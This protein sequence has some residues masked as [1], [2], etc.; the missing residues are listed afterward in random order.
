MNEI[1]CIQKRNMDKINIVLCDDHPTVRQGL[2]Y[3]MNAQDDLQV[4]GETDSGEGAIKL[5][6][7][8]AP[9]VVL[10][11]LQL[12]GLDGASA[13][14]EVKRISPRTQVVVLTSYGNN[15]D[16]FPALR[17]GATAYLLKDASMDEIADA[18]RR[19]ARGEV[20]FD[21]RIAHRILQQQDPLKE[22]T[23]RELEVLKLIAEGKTNEEIAQQF[24]V[25]INTVKGHVSNI[26]SK[27][28]LQDRTQAASFAWREGVMRPGG[29][30][31]GTTN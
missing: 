17:A 13:T 14:R 21:R 4:I 24:V 2:R 10:M 30:P 18:V 15:G 9:D 6:E 23:V 7:E 12:N 28:H 3:F 19:A 29:R 11:D 1:H 25:S 22:L 31:G 8:L 26:L 20:V 27:L 5:A 16:V